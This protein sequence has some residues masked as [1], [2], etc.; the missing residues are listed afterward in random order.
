[1]AI[2]G[3]GATPEP[4]QNNSDRIKERDEQYAASIFQSL[5][6]NGD[7]QIDEQDGLDKS[8]LSAL[9]K[10][11]GSTL[12]LDNFKKVAG[13]LSDFTYTKKAQYNGRDAQITYNIWGQIRSVNTGAQNE[14]EA[15]RHMGLDKKHII[16]RDTGDI[17]AYGREYKKNNGTQEEYFVWNPQTKS[18][19]FECGCWSADPQYKWYDP[20]GWF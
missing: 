16:G 19:D 9:K 14:T 3:V 20:R 7:N 2:S 10:F 17:T 11:V 5:N 15:R 8:M 6:K 1:M 13:K 12:T 4:Q 18:M